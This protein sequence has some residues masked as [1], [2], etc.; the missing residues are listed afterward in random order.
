MA[1]TLPDSDTFIE[2]FPEFED[3]D[4]E[5]ITALITEAARQVDTTW[6]EGD[7]TQAIMYLVAHL[8]SSGFDMA[9]TAAG[10][11]GIASET[12]GRISVSYRDNSAGKGSI[13]SSTGYGQR[14]LALRRL[15]VGGPI[16]V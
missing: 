13:L 14:F 12:L 8:L 10:G 6:T 9:D 11:A 15:N 16:V 3:T 5:L 4:D 1:Y 2:R 7:Y